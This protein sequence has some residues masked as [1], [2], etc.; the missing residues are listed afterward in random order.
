MTS[1]ATA[2]SKA[3]KSGATRYRMYIDGRFVDAASGK[4]IA[5]FDAGAG[6]TASPAIAGGKVVIGS[7]DGTLYALG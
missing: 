4:K 1:T 5:E 2:K 3:R 6:L 7:Q